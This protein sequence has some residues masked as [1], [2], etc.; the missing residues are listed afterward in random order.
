MDPV[1]IAVLALPTFVGIMSTIAA[2]WPNK[3]SGKFAQGVCDFI[4]ICGM[5]VGQA[6]NKE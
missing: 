2:K 3:A 1:T 5:N 6:K 4:N